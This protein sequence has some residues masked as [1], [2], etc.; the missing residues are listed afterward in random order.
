MLHDE[1]DDNGQYHDLPHYYAPQPYLLPDPNMEG[2]SGGVASL[3]DRPLPMNPVDIPP[4][5]TATT[6]S[7]RKSSVPALM[8]PVNIIQHDDAG[9][10]EGPANVGEP[11]TIEL[12]PAYTHIRSSQ[13]SPSTVPSPTI[14]STPSATESTTS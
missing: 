5:Q 10:S 3:R 12:P 2:A 6:T 1:D 11:E 4:P 7:T 13:R 9:P 8:R 14:A